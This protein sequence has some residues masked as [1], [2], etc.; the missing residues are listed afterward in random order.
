LRLA[1]RLLVDNAQGQAQRNRQIR[2]FLLAVT[3]SRKS[4][5]PESVI[6]I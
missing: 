4:P 2:I 5:P 6:T 3:R 1:Q